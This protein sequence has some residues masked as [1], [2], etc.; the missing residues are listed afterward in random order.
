MSSLSKDLISIRKHRKISIND[1]FEKSRIPVNTVESIENGSI[2]NEFAH[3]RTYLRGFLRTYARTLGIRDEDMS[4]ALDHYEKGT[5]KGFLVEKY[6][7]ND[8]SEPPEG[9]ADKTGAAGASAGA[10]EGIEGGPKAHGEG[11]KGPDRSMKDRTIKDVERLDKSLHRSKATVS[12]GDES[13]YIQSGTHRS[14]NIEARR[15]PTATSVDWANTLHHINQAESKNGLYIGILIVLLVLGA[16]SYF[17]Y[18]YFF[19]NGVAPFPGDE[20]TRPPLDDS[21][22]TAPGMADTLQSTQQPSD[23]P[24]VQQSPQPPQEQPEDQE[25]G[26]SI[27]GTITGQQP[28]EDDPQDGQVQDE[29]TG[30]ALGSEASEA[31]PERLLVSDDGRDAG[32]QPEETPTAGTPETDTLQDPEPEG[33]LQSTP[34][35][36]VALADTLIVTVHADEHRLEPVR[37]RSDVD[38]MLRPY[39][40]EQG[41]AL[42]FPFVDLIQISG[43]LQDMQVIINGHVIEDIEP[44]LNENR[45]LT[46]DRTYLASHPGLWNDE[47]AHTFE[48]SDLITFD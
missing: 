20:D 11:A 42:R 21:G 34:G 30:E 31:R 14:E 10:S 16:G 41:E 2:F 5:Y 45:M 33:A 46:L 17:T 48:E 38:N 39:W 13:E 19:S 24:P 47:G 23:Q 1:V 6:L 26:E 18:T 37:V 7:K 36:T 9:Q 32:E 8:T 12:T 40:I 27:E 29:E 43:E 4:E 3:N 15:P 44:L 22:E 25:A 28:E 35:E